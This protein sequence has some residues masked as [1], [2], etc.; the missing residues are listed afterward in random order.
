MSTGADCH[1]REVAEN[2]WHY[3]LQCYPYGAT[4]E[5]DRYGPFPT[6]QDAIDHL[7]DNHANPGGWC[8]S[9]FRKDEE[10]DTR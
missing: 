7:D 9:S 8:S 10:G 4:E 5:Y 1:I 6:E 3:T 2:Q